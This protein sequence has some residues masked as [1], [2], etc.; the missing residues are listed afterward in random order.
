MQSNGITHCLCKQWDYDTKPESPM[1]SCRQAPPHPSLYLGG[2]IILL[3]WT[4]NK[5]ALCPWGSLY[6]YFQG[7]LPWNKSCQCLCSQD[8]PCRTQET[9]EL[10][11]NRLQFSFVPLAES[12]M[13]T[14]FPATSRRKGCYIIKYGIKYSLKAV[15]SVKWRLKSLSI[16]LQS[17]RPAP[18]TASFLLGSERDGLF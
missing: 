5:P 14:T 16:I 1:N 10:S 17:E 7:C 4:A 18:R 12:N 9:R 8:L 13:I 2:D 3:F 11:P 6:L 15:F